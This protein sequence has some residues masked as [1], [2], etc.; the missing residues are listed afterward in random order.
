MPIVTVS[1]DYS[2]SSVTLKVEGEAVAKSNTEPTLATITQSLFSSLDIRQ[3]Q[4]TKTITADQII[5]KDLSTVLNR[6]L[7]FVL[8]HQ[9]QGTFSG[10]VAIRPLDFVTHRL[11]VRQGEGI[12][13]VDLTTT[14][15][16]DLAEV[17]E[18]MA[19]DLP[20]LESIKTKQP[21]QWYAQPTGI[22]ALL[23][24]GIGVAAAIALSLNPSNIA[25]NL[26]EENTSS[27]VSP[28]SPE[29]AGDD[30]DAEPQAA[31]PAPAVPETD[32]TDLA[33]ETL[34]ASDQARSQSDE[35]TA[36]TALSDLETL[37]NTNWTTPADLNTALTYRVFLSPDGEIIAVDP[38]DE[39]SLNRL[40]DTP[41]E[42]YPLADDTA[43]TDLA[44]AEVIEVQLDLDDQVTLV[45]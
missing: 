7:T 4:T 43:D 39:I 5:L 16:F 33:Q 42:E 30:P 41:L 24:G 31:L 23:V 18:D 8:T 29:S 9:S 44:N 38:Q 22:A 34:D 3:A 13:Q 17:I 37:L 10:T 25:E 27:L 2:H 6:Y 28:T 32:A 45:D 26:A 12:A 19:A 14:Q 21:R 1:Q 11:T 36:I 15:L 40:V 35:T 20:Q